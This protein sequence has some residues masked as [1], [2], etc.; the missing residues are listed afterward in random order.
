MDNV[1]NKVSK[2]IESGATQLW[3]EFKA[4]PVKASLKLLVFL[5][6]ADWLYG[7]LFGKETEA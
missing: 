1:L 7:K 5:V 6:V 3:E 4:K 2:G